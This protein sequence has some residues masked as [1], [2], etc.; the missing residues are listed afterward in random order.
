MFGLGPMELVIIAVILMVVFG[1]GKLPGVLADLAKG[2][3]SFRDGV[4]D[5][6]SG[7]E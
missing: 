7:P 4:T 2:L 3:R 6:K 5:D 1:A